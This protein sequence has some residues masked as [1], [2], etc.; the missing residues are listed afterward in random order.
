MK[1]ALSLPVAILELE[2]DFPCP[3]TLQR[4]RGGAKAANERESEGVDV[5]ADVI[6]DE[7]AFSDARRRV[8]HDFERRYVAWLLSKHH[9]NV[10]RAAAAAGIARRYLY[11][12]RARTEP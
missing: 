2:G 1:A 12:I 3:H 6:R 11:A 7:L 5:I 4:V 8:L 9:G 10:S